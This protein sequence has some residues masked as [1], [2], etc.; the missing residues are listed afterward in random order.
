MDKKIKDRPM[1][2]ARVTLIIKKK[3]DKTNSFMF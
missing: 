1:A 2:R 3:M